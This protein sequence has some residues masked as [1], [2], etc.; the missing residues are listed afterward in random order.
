M[1]GHMVGGG[2]GRCLK[3]GVENMLFTTRKSVSITGERRVQNRVSKCVITTEGGCVYTGG[4]VRLQLGEGV[5][6][7]CDDIRGKMCSLHRKI[8]SQ[9]EKKEK[10]KKKHKKTFVHKGK[11]LFVKQ[12]KPCFHV[13]SNAS[14]F[15]TFDIIIIIVI[16][17]IIRVYVLSQ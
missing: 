11:V 16:T 5:G 14:C 15:P 8:C 6:E 17:V 3:Q 10:K 7:R 9:L 4:K 13:S 12:T 2:G 1:C